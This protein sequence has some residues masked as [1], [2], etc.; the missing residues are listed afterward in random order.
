[1]S[2][3][4]R[5]LRQKSAKKRSLWVINE[6]FERIF[7]AVIATQVIHQRFFKDNEDFQQALMKQREKSFCARMLRL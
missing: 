7:N 4:Q 5:N 6:H 2:A 3:R 1:M